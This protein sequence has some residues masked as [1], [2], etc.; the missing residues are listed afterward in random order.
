[1]TGAKRVSF[2]LAVRPGRTV[3][4]LTPLFCPHHPAQV[5]VIVST[6]PS[7]SPLQYWSEKD[8]QGG[9]LQRPEGADPEANS[10]NTTTP[11]FQPEARGPRDTGTTAGPRGPGG[12]EDSGSTLIAVFST[13]APGPTDVAVST[14][15]VPQDPVG[16]TGGRPLIISS[17]SSSL[18]GRRLASLKRFLISGQGMC[19]DYSMFLAIVF[20]EWEARRSDL[21]RVFGVNLSFEIGSIKWRLKEYVV[22]KPWSGFSENPEKE[23]RARA[24]QKL[25]NG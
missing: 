17:S 5:A 1:M 9:V 13:P 16:L 20:A 11:P 24:G 21:F 18:G 8:P 2:R 7:T 3:P 22:E 25:M 6:D 12:A 19:L 14:P 15:G 23:I 4:G 10:T